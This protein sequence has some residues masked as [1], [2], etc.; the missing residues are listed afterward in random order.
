MNIDVVIER[1]DRPNSAL[2]AENMHPKNAPKRFG[3]VSK[4]EAVW[5]VR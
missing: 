4:S 1:A 3:S 2:V 5:E